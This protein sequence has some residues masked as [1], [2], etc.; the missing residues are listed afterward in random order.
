VYGGY[1]SGSGGTSAA[2]PV[3]AG[4]IALLNDAR[5]KKGLGALGFINPW[6]YGE[7]SDFLVDITKGASRG[8]DGTNHQSGKTVPGAAVIPGAFWNATTGWD[9]A[10][11]L[12]VF[13]FAKAMEATLKEN[14]DEDPHGGGYGHW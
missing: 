8:C 1:L 12:G 13:N 14:E 5:L 10:T 6:L 11:G 2:A 3:V 4:I 9:A 7:G